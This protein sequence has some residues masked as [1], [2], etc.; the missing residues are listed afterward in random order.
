MASELPAYPFDTFTCHLREMSAVPLS[1]ATLAALYAHYQELRRWNRRLSLIGPGTAGEVLSRHYGESLAALPWLRPEDQVLV[2]VGS[3]AG[4]PGFVLAAAR[5]GLEV[6]LVESRERKWSFLKSAVRRAEA[7]QAEQGAASSALSCRCINARI[8]RSLPPAL[9]AG[10]DIV[11]SRAAGLSPDVLG[12]FVEH[13]PQVRF[14]LWQGARRWLPFGF[15]VLKLHKLSY[16]QQRW[17]VEIGP[18]AAA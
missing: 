7:A 18:E 14:F 1:D 11:T 6:Y 4:F 12:T 17:L 3:G 5:P 13:S 8:E 15:E 2:D 10:I 9:P 16:S